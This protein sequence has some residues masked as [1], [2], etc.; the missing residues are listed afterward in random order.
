MKWDSTLSVFLLILLVSAFPVTGQ[1]KPGSKGN[2]SELIQKRDPSQNVFI[3]ALQAG[4]EHYRNGNP[5]LEANFARLKELTKEAALNNPKPELICFPEYAI[6]GWPYPDEAIINGLAEN[7]PGNGKWY[8]QYVELARKTDVAILGWLVE[9]D[10]GKLYNTAFII[11]NQGNFKGKYRKVQANLG[12]QVWWGWSQGEQF[13]LIELNG[14]KYGISICADMWFP[15]TVR[16]EEL[17]GADVIIHISVADDMGHLIP[18][19]AFDSKLPIVAAIFQGGSYA[20]DDD[21]KML[22]K[23]PGELP[24]WKSFEIFP[25]KQHLGK[26]YGGIWDTKKGGH[27]I[28]NV[29]AYSILTDPGTRPSWTEIFMDNKGYPQTKEQLIKRFNGR[30]DA[31]DPLQYKLP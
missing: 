29:G 15:E 5:G 19:R 28:R 4:T 26:K 8:R 23:L 12:E 14:V 18:A 3:V 10:M 6:S 7:I 1:D 11:D 9:K 20:V 13:T 21:G 22:G 2:E 30:Y 31:N 16:C 24:A 25:F 27:N 17:L